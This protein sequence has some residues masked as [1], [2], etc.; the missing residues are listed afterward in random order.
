MS[1]CLL[2][3]VGIIFITATFATAQSF[4]GTI[5]GTVKDSTGAVLPGVEV[6]V[7]NTETRAARTVLTN[8]TGEYAAALLPP[9]TY[10]VQT[11]LSGFKTEARSGITLQVDQVA[12]IDFTL[13]VGEVSEKVEVIGDAPLINTESS[14][15]G[16]VIEN[17]KVV[18][19]PL[20]GRQFYQLNLLLPGASTSV[21]GSQNS[22]Q[23][24]SFVVNGAR[25]QDNNFLIDGID[26]NDLAIN[27][28][29]VPL[30]VDAIQ[31]FKLQASS[32]T[33][34]FGRS[35]GAQINVSTKSGTNNIHGTLFQF[36]RNSALDAKNFFD[37]P[38]QPIPPFKRN[39]FGGSVGGPIRKD[40]TF[41]FFNADITRVRQAVTQL[42]RV[43]SEQERNGDFSALGQPPIF[44][45][46]TFDPTGRTRQP[47]PG[48]RIPANRI[49]PV[50][51][52]VLDTFVPLPNRDGQ[53]NFLS[54]PT[55]PR[56]IAQWTTKI[57][58]KISP[59]DDVFGRYTFNDDKRFNEYEPFGRWADIPNFGTHTI[60]RHQHAGTSWIHIFSPN[61]IN[62]LKLGYNR[63]T[64]GIWHKTFREREDRN[65][66]VGIKGTIRSPINFGLMRMS[67]PGFTN[68]GDRAAQNRHDNTY[69][70][71]DTFSFISGN[72]RFKWGIDVRRFQI[73][74]LI[75]GREQVNFAS[76]FTSNPSNPTG[77]GSAF[78][79]FLL[80][81]PISASLPTVDGG[82][83]SSFVYYQRTTNSSYYFQDDWKVH[84]KLTL[85]LGIRYELNTPVVEHR[86]RLSNFD[87][88][89]G[90]VIVA[91]PQ[92]RKLYNT[93]TNNFAPRFGFAWTPFANA[94]LSVRGGYG[95]FYS[96]KLLNVQLGLAATPP[97]RATLIF[98]SSRD[99]PE[100]RID[101]PFSGLGTAPRP[102][103]TSIGPDFPDGYVQQ[104]SSSVQREIVRDLVLDL[105]YVGSKGTKLDRGYDPNQPL[106]GLGNVIDR[107]P[108]P[109]FGS[110]SRP[111]SGA[112]SSYHS[113]QTK[114]EK[115]FSQGLTFLSSYTWS[116]SIDNAS[117]WNFQGQ[118]A[119]NFRDD[120]GLSDFNVRHRYTFSYVYELPFGRSRKFLSSPG[121]VSNGLLGGWQINGIFTRQTGNPFTVTIAQD[122]ANV[123]T[124][125]QR[126]NRIANANLPTNQ[127]TPEHWFNTDAFVLPANFTFGNAGRNV[128]EVPGPKNMDFSLIKNFGVREGQRVEFRAEFFNFT[129]HP[130]LDRPLAT[131]DAPTTFGR[132]LS[133]NQNPSRQIQFGL[134]YYF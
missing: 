85:N 47:F 94:K 38:D 129:N 57:D 46:L 109:N 115:R 15:V 67:I 82:I 123:G 23:G 128:F 22:T 95:V 61:V 32:Y 102:S 12:R 11:A 53:L 86:N 100:I 42:A 13:Q 107:R 63:F 16:T 28:F 45:P 83:T 117:S 111:I 41:Y 75:D 19:L 79:D 65:T 62:D 112:G 29:S 8:E 99:I 20:N 18:E 51:R 27:I 84:P 119:Y 133:A 104:W 17:R 1:R 14:T 68:L 106:P 7:T 35:G 31:E 54:A 55:A 134:K 76:N 26:N 131:L 56:N 40:R 108:F 91:T 118:N 66:A 4:R 77:T 49:N 36:L 60:N 124:G 87:V 48:N 30:S 105:G 90:T 50:T 81:F 70:F 37:K 126:P 116:K 69:Q 80:G 120:R 114:L 130:I 89:T 125:N 103:A 24:G 64:G 127:R 74:I 3:A 9:G 110:I 113:F 96:T 21:Q 34:E 101:D 97:Y 33:A 43:P 92:H 121:R 58:H 6:I 10:S 25:E 59:N 2:I 72:H 98:A 44:D 78:A 73:N 71:S 122:R 39:Q 132:I 5:V 88:T 93:D 52:R